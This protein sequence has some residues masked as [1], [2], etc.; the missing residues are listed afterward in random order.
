MMRTE[1][2]QTLLVRN[3]TRTVVGSFRPHSVVYSRS[4]DRLDMIEDFHNVSR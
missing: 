3:E 1:F 4:F 2:I